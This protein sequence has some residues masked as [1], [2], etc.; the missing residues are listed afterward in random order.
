MSNLKLPEN[1]LETQFQ[2]T[3]PLYSSIEAGVEANRCLFCYDAP[4]INACPAGIDIP[5]FIGKIRSGNIDGAARTIL[6][7]NMAGVTTARVCP[8]EELCVGACVLND[9]NSQPVQ[10]GRLQR[11]ATEKALKAEDDSGRKLFAPRPSIGKKV[12]L[13]GGGPASLSCAAHLAL[14][15][16]EAVVYEKE[17]ILGGLNTT[18]I[19]PYK[20]KALDS[21]KEVEWMLNHGISVR[22]GVAVGHDVQVDELI[23]DFDALFIGIGLGKDGLPDIPGIEGPNIWGAT[24]LIKNIKMK[25]NFALPSSMKK[26]IVIGGGNTAIDVA[27]ELAMLNVAEVDIL[28]RRTEAEMPG[29]K[30]EMANARSR[31]VRIIEHVK[32]LE[33][34]H[35]A[36]LDLLA[37]NSITGE[38]LSFQCDCLVFAI[39]QQKLAKKLFPEINA[40]AKGRIVVDHET[41]LTSITN[42]YAGGDCINGGKEVVNAVADGR[43]AAYAMLSSWGIQAKYENRQEA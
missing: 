6:K 7:V 22:S 27:R 19:A 15:G 39:G 37:E 16:V 34:K 40:D 8:V 18:G 3:K 38:S 30:H 32:P 20:L 2:V 1:R 10:I 12:A 17:D 31:G 29:Y 24:D 41:G 25:S 23:Q 43:D 28:Y 11:Y 9:L 42:V 21:L 4:C 5:A 26:A 33:I 14:E 13:I 36:G 35:G